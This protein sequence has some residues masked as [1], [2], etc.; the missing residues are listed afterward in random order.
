MNRT[1]DINNRIDGHLILSNGEV[2]TD[3]ITLGFDERMNMNPR[4]LKRLGIRNIKCEIVDNPGYPSALEVMY[5]DR[6]S[7]GSN[8][9]LFKFSLSLTTQKPIEIAVEIVGKLQA[10]LESKNKTYIIVNM[11]FDDIIYIY[12]SNAGNSTDIFEFRMVNDYTIDHFSFFGGESSVNRKT[13]NLTKSNPY[14]FI[15]CYNNSNGVY[16]N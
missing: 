9:N 15:Y 11:N 5:Y 14:L 16:D 8:M 4:K 3:G 13:M 7:G 2:S 12:W 10:F 6:S 1:N